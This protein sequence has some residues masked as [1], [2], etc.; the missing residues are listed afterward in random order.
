MLA[1]PRQNVLRALRVLVTEHEERARVLG[2]YLLSLERAW[3]LEERATVRSLADFKE[4][5][6]TQPASPQEPRSAQDP[7]GD[8]AVP[9]RA[10][11]G[12]PP[13]GGAGAEP[14]P[15]PC[16][17]AFAKALE[18][19]TDAEGYGSLLY[20]DWNWSGKKSRADWRF[21]ADLPPLNYCPWC[22]D[23]V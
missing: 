20:R 18:A 22:G 13:V 15:D 11:P 16:C 7:A 12:E 23:R 5:A 21:C 14:R 1:D 9:L 8:P 2:A 10:G 19:G 3:A 4:T 17:R 6:P